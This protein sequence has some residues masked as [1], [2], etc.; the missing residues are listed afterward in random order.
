[1]SDKDLVCDV[2]A[3]PCP[4]IRWYRNG[5]PVIPDDY[6]QLSDSQM[7]R[8]MGFSMSDSAIYQCIASNEAGSIQMM[9]QIIAKPSG[10]YTVLAC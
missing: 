10:W 7:L 2:Y 9:S 6:L 8:I 3:N 5:E 4:T 1:M